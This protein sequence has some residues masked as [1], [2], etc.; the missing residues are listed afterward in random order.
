[1]ML[2]ELLVG[3]NNSENR[4]TRVR[5]EESWDAAIKQPGA[6]ET[7]FQIAGAEGE[8][9]VARMHSVI[10]I[11]NF[12]EEN[13]K[14]RV[15][16]EGH[17]SSERKEAVKEASLHLLNSHHQD[18]ALMRQIAVLIAK[19]SRYEI[20]SWPNLLGSIS[21]GVSHENPITRVKFFTTLHYLLYGCLA[22]SRI[23]SRAAFEG[24][25]A[26]ITPGCNALSEQ[27]NNA[28]L[29][30]DT[31]TN[32]N[33]KLCCL[34][35]KIMQRALRGTDITSPMACAYFTNTV[36]FLDK[37]V[38]LRVVSS[39]SDKSSLLDSVIKKAMKSVST[40]FF[41][42]PIE[43]AQSGAIS[44]VL[45]LC[46]QKL[47]TIPPFTDKLDNTFFLQS[48]SVIEQ[49]IA[50]LSSSPTVADMFLAVVPDADLVRFVRVLLESYLNLHQY[51]VEAWEAD[52]E[53]YV[54][55]QE[56]EDDLNVKQKASS[57][58]CGL[59]DEKPDV[60]IPDLA[61]LI[62][63]TFTNPNSSPKDIETALH[64]MGLGCYAFPSYM[65][66]EEPR[67]MQ[68]LNAAASM[69]AHTNNYIKRRAIWVIGQWVYTVPPNMYQAI[70]KLLIDSQC[71]PSNDKVIKLTALNAMKEYVA[72]DLDADALMPVL[73][74]F[75]G[76]TF[77]I[78]RQCSHDEM[79]DNCL[80][81]IGLVITCLGAERFSPFAPSLVELLQVYWTTEMDPTKKNG[82]K[83]LE[84]VIACLAKLVQVVGSVGEVHDFVCCVI[85]Q[86]TDVSNPMYLDLVDNANELWLYTILN[87]KE[88]TPGLAACFAHMLPL[89][90]KSFMSYEHLLNILHQY[91]LIGG[92]NLL[93]QHGIA[94][95]D[96]LVQIVQG[97]EGDVVFTVCKI[98][99]DVIIM[100]PDSA[101]TACP[102]VSSMLQC[103][104]SPNRPRPRVQVAFMCVVCRLV[105]G[106][107]TAALQVLSSP[108]AIISCLDLIVDLEDHVSC[109]D[110]RKI[111][112]MAFSSLLVPPHAQVL[113]RMD[114]VAT[115]VVEA[116]TGEEDEFAETFKT[117]VIE[118]RT[119]HFNTQ[120][121][122]SLEREH[123]LLNKDPVVHVSMRSWFATQLQAIHAVL[124]DEKYAA[125][126]NRIESYNRKPLN[127]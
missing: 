49:V 6:L 24:L 117:S 86:S 46:F 58:F 8:D 91:I 107:K 15:G 2:R 70:Y 23:G 1:M 39:A 52:P 111:C 63:Q 11:R 50:S 73:N 51:E 48:L 78:L 12:V 61:A 85:K 105:V 57:V 112:A 25:C 13:W 121:S 5:C 102:L 120:T 94:I 60:F 113:E 9:M 71:N 54:F 59:A 81:N 100:C 21:Q 79:K 83:V 56:A 101:Q 119:S 18:D 126:I 10:S 93:Q 125:V 19:I 96:R 17:M 98:A 40:L 72:H 62:E 88:L 26:S 7:V 122:H 31:I 118:S 38:E 65:S 53:S 69:C 103:I 109:P 27:Y 89:L 77:Q 67:Q 114:S 110:K 55:D 33:A 4:E 29:S 3:R 30:T 36:A 75:F 20:A 35:H 92:L 116:V 68:W 104:Y 74:Q 44:P 37:A 97:M 80:A 76:S 47:L 32:L 34:C 22:A 90:D 95:F 84:Q 127:L 16:L 106:N 64:V 108:E 41:H 43:M 28:M 99:E 45:K 123:A 124:G 82:T 87:A 14:L 42:K 115:M 66:S